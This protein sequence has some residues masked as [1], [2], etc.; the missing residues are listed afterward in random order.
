[1][2]LFDGYEDI[3]DE[4]DIIT[5]SPYRIAYVGDVVLYEPKTDSFNIAADRYYDCLPLECVNDVDYILIGIVIRQNDDHSVDVMMCNFLM[6]N[7]KFPSYHIDY[8][9]P[10]FMRKSMWDLYR[11]YVKQFWKRCPDYKAL[12]DMK[13][14]PISVVDVIDICENMEYFFNCYK[15]IVG[16][17]IY[18]KFVTRLF[19]ANHVMCLHNNVIYT[20]KLDVETER[21]YEIEIPHFTYFDFLCVFRNINITDFNV[22]KIKDSPKIQ[23]L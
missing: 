7:Q 17:S 1:M 5:T 11:R 6:D 23:I 4:S 20:A 2:S 13:M 14:T 16:D 8:K 15:A 3:L 22:S 10:K 21:I 19:E 9:N 18:T 12:F